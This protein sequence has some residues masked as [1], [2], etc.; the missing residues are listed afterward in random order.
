MTAIAFLLHVGGG[1]IA[2]FAGVTAMLARKGGPI[3]RW[4]G[5]TFF[6]SMLVMAVFAGYLA[7]VRPG[8]IVNLV[9]AIFVAYL[10]STAWLTVTRKEGVS[11]ISERLALALSGCLA[12]SFLFIS[13][14]LATRGRLPFEAKALEGPELIAIYLF[15]SIIVIAALSDLKVVIMGGIT[16]APR[17]ARHLWRMCLG[18]TLATGSAFTNG[19][20]RLLPGYNGD[21]SDYF[22]LPQLVP[23]GFLVFWMIRVRLSSWSKTA[24]FAP[25]TRLRNNSVFAAPTMQELG[26]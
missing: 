7:I 9:I 19:L 18:L 13:F 21:V 6:V 5:T 3:H 22:L 23:I 24:Q 2:L 4:A 14:Q 12:A 25:A 17:I 16:G 20:P 1:T 11:G 15:T 8:Q 26:S 10:V